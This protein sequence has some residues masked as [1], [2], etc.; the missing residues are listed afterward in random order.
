MKYELDHTTTFE[1]IEVYPGFFKNI[2]EETSTSG[3]EDLTIMTKSP[4]DYPHQGDCFQS[5]IGSMQDM[6][7]IE[8]KSKKKD[9]L[10]LPVDGN[11]ILTDHIL[12]RGIQ[13]TRHARKG[14]RFQG[15]VIDINEQ[16]QEAVKKRWNSLTSGDIIVFDDI[17][18]IETITGN[19]VRND[20]LVA[21]HSFNAK[22]DFEHVLRIETIL[23]IYNDLHRVNTHTQ[24]DIRIKV[25]GGGR[26]VSLNEFRRIENLQHLQSII[27]VKAI[28]EGKKPDETLIS[29]IN[30]NFTKFDKY[31]SLRN[32]TSFEY[33]Q[34]MIVDGAIIRNA[35]EGGRI[36][37]LP[38]AKL[39]EM[40]E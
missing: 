5:F 32:S 21:I 35:G 13:V 40:L 36:D 25:T 39:R 27:T 7:S 24:A 20:E 14:L 23:P 16:D 22:N 15:I 28:L 10:I 37:I 4:D 12:M 38:V 18:T 9:I 34:E 31:G 1:Q 2:L 11:Y 8:I 33:F 6:S 17:E 3:L 26:S 30:G 29:W 19:L